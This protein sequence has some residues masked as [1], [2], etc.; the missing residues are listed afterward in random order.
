[1]ILL[2]NPTERLVSVVQD[3]S[4]PTTTTSLRIAMP[5]VL[6]YST[7][8]NGPRR[9]RAVLMRSGTSKGL[10]FRREDL[11]TDREDWA[12]L[13]LAAM[14]SPDSYGRQ[15][16]GCGGGTSTQSKVAVVGRCEDSSI[17]DIDYTF[18]QVGSNSAT[19]DFSGYCRRR[20]TKRRLV[21]ERLT[22]SPETRRRSGGRYLPRKNEELGR[23]EVQG[24]SCSEQREG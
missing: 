18:C 15:L 2:F 24:L 19:L 22:L 23:R 17:A 4:F 6:T 8:S 3:C 13:I 7:P 11:P 10:F 20:M 5:S 12:P 21:R 1:M 9:L 14:G 16:N